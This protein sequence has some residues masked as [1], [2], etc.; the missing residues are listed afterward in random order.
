MQL[1]SNLNV[2]GNYL[3]DGEKNI[4][5]V[6]KE[7]SQVNKREITFADL[8]DAVLDQEGKVLDNLTFEEFI[9]KLVVKVNPEIATKGTKLPEVTVSGALS[10]QTVDLILEASKAS[11]TYSLTNTATKGTYTDG[12][13]KTHAI[14][15]GKSEDSESFV[16]IGCEDLSSAW[17]GDGGNNT[18]TV[19]L[20][21]RQFVGGEEAVEESKSMTVGNITLTE[22]YSA[23]TKDISL[24]ASEKPIFRSSYGNALYTTA[25]EA[26]AAG[27]CTKT[28]TN[29]KKVTVSTKFYSWVEGQDLAHAT[30]GN[31][32][33]S[34]V[35]TLGDGD[36]IIYPSNKTLQIVW[37]TVQPDD[38][39][40]SAQMYSEV[41]K[42]I[43]LPS[44]GIATLLDVAPTDKPYKTYKVRTINNNFPPMEAKNNCKIIIS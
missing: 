3:K 27:T 14:T 43:A 34:G 40:I 11:A 19:S 28:T 31:V 36:V 42:Y 35:L 15:M 30:L 41:T 33:K 4:G 16:N 5:P 29:G 10:G 6:R 22:S 32:S 24:D 12:Q 37:T 1:I 2:N 26:I 20:E 8:Q 44:E 39:S 18:K 7:I 38:S 9:E 23:S 17:D 13:A 21:M 25:G